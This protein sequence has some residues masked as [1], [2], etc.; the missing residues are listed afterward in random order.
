MASSR[1]V[2]ASLQRNLLRRT[3]LRVSTQCH[4]LAPQGFRARSALSSPRN[5]LPRYGQRAFSTS[6]ARRSAEAEEEF[7]PNSIERESDE[8]D[9]C[10]VGGG[11]LL[12][13]AS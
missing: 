7:D 12:A 6:I 5:I 10:I 8:V 9:V 11:M 4:R 13:A 3:P 1:S 2:T